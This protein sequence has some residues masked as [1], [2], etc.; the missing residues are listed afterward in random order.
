MY[1]FLSDGE[2]VAFFHLSQ[3]NSAPPEPIVGEQVEYTLHTSKTGKTYCTE[4]V[5]LT[6]PFRLKGVVCHFDST[7]GYGKVK[8]DDGSH[9]FLHRSEMT[10]GRHPSKGSEVLFYKGILKGEKRAV[11]ID[12]KEQG[13]E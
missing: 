12:L 13:N 3:F 1:G 9:Y 11:Y 4:V 10:D 2:V 7:K 5:R 8:A 6:E